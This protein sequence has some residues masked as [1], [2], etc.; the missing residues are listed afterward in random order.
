M[1]P[2]II[3]R[4]FRS[5]FWCIMSSDLVDFATIQATTVFLI[6]LALI[7][8][9]E[10]RHVVLL[11]EEMLSFG[12]IHTI[13]ARI[14]NGEVIII[15]HIIIT[16]AKPIISAS[17]IDKRSVIVHFDFENV[18]AIED[19][20]HKDSIDFV[21]DF[22]IPI[23]CITSIQTSRSYRKIADG[24]VIFLLLIIVQVSL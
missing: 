16:V 22:W 13:R 9:I 21:V 4:V 1:M 5:S 3:P 18:E 24:P 23:S 8:D 10:Y 17:Q 15:V 14:A 19:S 11:V 20:K 7:N 2:W 6:S 12:L